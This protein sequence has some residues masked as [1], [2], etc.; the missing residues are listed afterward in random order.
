MAQS[1]ASMSAMDSGTP[2]CAAR[3]RR[4]YFRP[5]G[6]PRTFQFDMADTPHPRRLA[7][8]ASPPSRSRRVFKSVMADSLSPSVKGCQPGINFTDQIVKIHGL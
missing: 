7:T 5:R 4:S 3:E 8:E 2:C 1:A 6:M